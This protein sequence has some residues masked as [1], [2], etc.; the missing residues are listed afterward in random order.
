MSL[1]TSSD[2]YLVGFVINTIEFEL[3]LPDDKIHTLH[4]MLDNAIESTHI[5]YRFVAKIAVFLQSL[6][7]AVGPVVRLF[8]RNMHFALAIRTCWNYIFLIPM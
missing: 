8:T 5:S 7:L 3:C 6:F 1:G 2:R 4:R